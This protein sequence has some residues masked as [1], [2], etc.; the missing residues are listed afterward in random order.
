MFDQLHNCEGKSPGS[1]PKE[2]IKKLLLAVEIAV[3]V[4]RA[5]DFWDP[6]LVN[7]L[8]ST[9]ENHGVS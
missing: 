9:L 6:L 1:V 5:V 3:G 2:E 8:V 7:S 4:D